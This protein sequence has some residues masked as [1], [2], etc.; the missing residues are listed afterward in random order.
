ME[1]LSGNVLEI[2]SFGRES[3]GSKIRQRSD[4][5]SLEASA[6]RLLLSSSEV[7]MMFQSCLY[8]ERRGQ[9]FISHI[10][11]PYDEGEL[12]REH[13]LGPGGCL[14]QSQSLKS[15]R[16]ERSLLGEQAS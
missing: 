3:G 9:A 7:G 4:V 8:L 2:S 5:V 16:A 12:G 14:Q 11:Q 15:L 10:R 1:S 6:R 13:D